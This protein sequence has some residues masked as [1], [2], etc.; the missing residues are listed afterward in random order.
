MRNVKSFRVLVTVFAALCMVA[1]LPG[2]FSASGTSD[3]TTTTHQYL[4]IPNSSWYSGTPSYTASPGGT[5]PTVTLK[6]GS[7][8]LT[9]GSTVTWEVTWE[10]TFEVEAEVS[11][12]AITSD[13]LDGYFTYPITQEDID[14]GYV[15]VDMELEESTPSEAI[16]NRDYRGNGT[17]YEEA[18]TGVTS[19]D[20]ALVNDVG[21]DMTGTPTGGVGITIGEVDTGGDGG[22][23]GG[24]SGDTVCSEWVPMC[25]CNM[26]ACSDGSRAWYDVGS[27][28]YYCASISNCT[29]AAQQA[30]DYCTRGC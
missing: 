25:S 2:C 19:T 4:I 20:F 17:C 22:D 29:S 10:A 16:C 13:D 7:P 18:D 11:M 12:V 1:F 28:V 26:R 23:G 9:V 15:D 24:S 27:G 8:V 30:V 6:E 21:G 14:N 5:A 3:N